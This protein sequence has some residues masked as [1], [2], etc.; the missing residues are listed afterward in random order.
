MEDLKQAAVIMKGGRPASNIFAAGE[1]M[2][3][4]ILPKG[5]IGGFGLVIGNVFGR[6][7]G[8]KAAVVART[9]R[10]AA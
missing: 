4:N 1:I 9:M 5:Y 6:T 10:K 2:S 7:A 8:G 3:G